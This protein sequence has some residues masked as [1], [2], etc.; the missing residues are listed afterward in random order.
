V[1]D[2]CRV[3]DA[4]RV[5]V[6]SFEYCL[7]PV[8][9]GARSCSSG[10]SQRRAARRAAHGTCPRTLSAARPARHR[11]PLRRPCLAPADLGQRTHAARGA[12]PCPIGRCPVRGA[13]CRAPRAECPV[14]SAQCPVQSAQCRVPSAVCPDHAQCRVCPNDPMPIV[15]QCPRCPIAPWCSVVRGRT[16]GLLSA[17]TSARRPMCATAERGRLPWPASRLKSRLL[18]V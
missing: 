18:Y 10:P 13:R 3:A 17:P 4:S 16:S 2:H 5:A 8:R 6:S 7:H 12:L 15:P 9:A 1:R 11:R 14:P